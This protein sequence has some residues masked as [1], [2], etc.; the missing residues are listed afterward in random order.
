M[1]LVTE[2]LYLR[3]NN[4]GCCSSPE[5]LNPSLN[6]FLNPF[7]NIYI[8]RNCCNVC[9]DVCSN[10]CPKPPVGT[11]SGDGVNYQNPQLNFY[12]ARVEEGEGA[13]DSYDPQMYT[14]VSLG[15]VLGFG[16]PV[17]LNNS[18]LHFSL[19]IHQRG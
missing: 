7:D 18:A 6:P 8:C 19:D 10:I 15:N 14:P 12:R 3:N 5:C 11:P 4:T 16:V 1:T 9:S 2:Q 13:E 17:S